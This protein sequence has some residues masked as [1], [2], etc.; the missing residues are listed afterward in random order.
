MFKQLKSL[1]YIITHAHDILIDINNINA[2]L[3]YAM[4]D[5]LEIGKIWDGICWPDKEEKNGK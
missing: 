2:T 1:W 5:G 4:Y 3:D